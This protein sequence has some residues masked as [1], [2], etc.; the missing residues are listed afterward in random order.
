[1]AGF[2]NKIDVCLGVDISNKVAFSASCN[3]HLDIE[4]I[5]TETGVSK[6]KKNQEFC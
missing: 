6:T 2:V 1:M 3:E 4:K 5:K